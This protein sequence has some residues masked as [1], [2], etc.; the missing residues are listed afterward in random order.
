MDT[1]GER[2]AN[3]MKARGKTPADLVRQNVLSKAAIYFWLD[4]TAKPDK[5]RADS[6]TKVCKALGVSREWLLTGRG[7]MESDPT[8]APSQPAR[9]DAFVLGK[10]A[11]LAGDIAG[12][13]IDAVADAELIAALYDELVSLAGEPI[14]TATI[15]A[16]AR[17]TGGTGGQGHVSAQ[18]RPDRGRR[19]SKGG[20]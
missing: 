15:A 8:T 3:A 1:L 2:L 5:V 17:K 6:V 13:P 7:S 18:D 16:F 20:T 11:E 10:A 4:G 19:A 12:R 14:P 9:L